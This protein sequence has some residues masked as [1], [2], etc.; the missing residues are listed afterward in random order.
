ME[1]RSHA[2]LA[3][4][5]TLA[6]LVAA[7]LVAIWVG[8]DRAALKPYVIVSATSVSGLSAQSTVRYQGVPVGKVQSLG[9]NPDKPAQVRISIGVAPDTPITE[10]TWAELGV[11]GVTGLGNIELRDDGTSTRRLASSAAMPA[12]IPL[13]PGFFQRFEQRGGEILHNVE[14]VSARLERLL[15]NENVQATTATL[16]NIAAITTD[17]RQAAT[18][19]RPALAQV[20][21]LVDS[22][23]AMSRNTGQA[24]QE[25]AGL[26]QAARQALARL[27][28]P[29]GPLAM[30]TRSMRDIAWAAARLDAQTLPAVSGMASSI[31]SAARSA[32]TTL[33]RVGD[34]PQS[35]LFG[36]PPTVPGPG[37]PGFAGFGR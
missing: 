26:A 28:A 33:R 5:F 31:D 23:Q 20:P 6:L 15:S 17:L 13:R 22:L 30:A 2:L 7:A 29:D 24:A 14:Q 37:E 35:L 1:N 34:T 9:F 10:S 11:Q 8:R 36:P 3:G 27:D 16:Q 25:I 12:T 21:P 4:L 19:L 32:T 18:D